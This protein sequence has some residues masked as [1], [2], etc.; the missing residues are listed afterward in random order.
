MFKVRFMSLKGKFSTL[1]EE[2]FRSLSSVTEAVKAHATSG[3]Y[4][5]W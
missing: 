5:D 3:A 1:R 4:T 2:S